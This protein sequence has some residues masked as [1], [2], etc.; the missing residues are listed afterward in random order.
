[1]IK[2]EF[3]KAGENFRMSYFTELCKTVYKFGAKIF[4]KDDVRR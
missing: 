4:L 1:M 3:K 2:N